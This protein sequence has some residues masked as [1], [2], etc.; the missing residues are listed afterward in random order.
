[1]LSDQWFTWR[2]FWKIYNKCL[3][4]APYWASKMVIWTNLNPQLPSM[5]PTKGEN[6]KSLQTTDE[7]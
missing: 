6:M 5:F 3:Y 1:M 2:I 7:W 4:F